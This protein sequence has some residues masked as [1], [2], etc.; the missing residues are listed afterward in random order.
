MAATR[1]PAPRAWMKSARH[2]HRRAAAAPTGGEGFGLR[3]DRFLSAICVDRT[4]A[5]NQ[6]DAGKKNICKAR[7]IARNWTAFMSASCAP[8]VR[9]RA[10]PIGGIATS[11]SA[12]RRCSRPSAGFRT[13]RTKI[14]AGAW[15]SLKTRSSSIAAI[16]IMNCAQVC[17][18]GL[19]P[20]EAIASIKADMVRTEVLNDQNFV[21][22]RA[23]Q[24]R[25][26]ER[27]IGW[28]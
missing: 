22:D 4:V 1:W 13:A 5:E 12:R 3:P 9:R 24:V 11:S 7:P 20:A 19:N 27:F 18:K 26:S 25:F 21:S 8:A 23:V 6:R 2:D 28:Q 17:P 10:R 14:P 15:I 16:R